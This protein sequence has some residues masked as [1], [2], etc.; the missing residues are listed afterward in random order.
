MWTWKSCNGFKSFSPSLF[1]VLQAA[2]WHLP[3]FSLPICSFFPLSFCSLFA[4]L[5]SLHIFLLVP[6]DSSSSED[7]CI[8]S[9]RAFFLGPLWLAPPL[10]L[11]WLL[12]DQVCSLTTFHMYIQNLASRKK[13][14]F[15][16]TLVVSPES[17]ECMQV[18][19]KRT[20]Q[21][22]NSFLWEWETQG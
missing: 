4:S 13:W 1:P 3:V 6:S 20:L 21:A 9:K 5:L 22:A 10:L 12:S 16:V 19:G 7:V 8:W 18:A 14:S 17:R 11:M 15:Q 2:G